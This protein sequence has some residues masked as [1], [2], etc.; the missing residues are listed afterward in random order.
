MEND[1]QHQARG[2]TCMSTHMHTPEYAYTQCTSHTLESVKRK[3]Y[4]EFT[5][6]CVGIKTTNVNY[7]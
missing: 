7:T 3:I 1:S 4:S 2:F 5:S 6:L